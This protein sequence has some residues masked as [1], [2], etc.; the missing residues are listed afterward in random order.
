MKPLFLLTIILTKISIAQEPYNL[1]QYGK[2]IVD[3]KTAKEIDAEWHAPIKLTLIVKDE[4]G[5]L[6]ADANA[7]VGIDSRLHMDGHNNFKGKTDKDGRF[8]VEARGGGSSDVLVDIDG[9]YPSRPNVEWDDKR[10][11][12]TENLR[13]DGFQP[14]NQTV[15]VTLKKIGT[16][17]PMTVRAG[18]GNTDHIRYAPKLDEEVGYDLVVGDWVIPHGSGEVGDIQVMFKSEFKNPENYST[19]ATFRFSN[20]DDGVIPITSL[21]GSESL[22]KYPRSAPA[23]G[24]EVKSITLTNQSGELPQPKKDPPI[25]YFLRLRTII[26][27]G[28]GKILSAKYGKVIKESGHNSNENPFKLSSGMWKERKFDPTPGFQISY[29]LNPTP[30]D[31]NLEYDQHNNLAPEADKGVTLAP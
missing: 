18:L 12:D 29:Y 11:L 28:T 21:I 16:P 20:P 5:N 22:L 15:N 4:E 1:N 7:N 6:V 13:K 25:G 26:E 17:I 14:W 3:E 30:N 8:T 10:N 9:Y 19:K 2:G 24:Y 31:R 27:T 23:N